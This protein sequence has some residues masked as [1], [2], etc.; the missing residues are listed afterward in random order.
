MMTRYN[1]GLCGGWFRD[2]YEK[3]LC[4]VVKLYFC[5]RISLMETWVY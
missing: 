5:H 1:L 4:G 2:D 3:L